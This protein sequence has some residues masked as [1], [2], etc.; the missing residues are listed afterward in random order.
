MSSVS[1]ANIYLSICDSG[2]SVTELLFLFL[3]ILLLQIICL[4]IDVSVVDR[5]VC[6][7]GVQ[8]TQLSRAPISDFFY[9]S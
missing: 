9:L 6:S 7:L 4:C 2:K 8:S 1:V 3:E 5:N